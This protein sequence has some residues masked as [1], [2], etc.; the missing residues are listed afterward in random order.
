MRERKGERERERDKQSNGAR[1][2]AKDTA[3]SPCTE[4]ATFTH[5]T[6]RSER[7]SPQSS[8]EKRAVAGGGREGGAGATPPLPPPIPL[9]AFLL[10]LL[11]RLRTCLASCCP[12]RRHP[13]AASA[14]L[15]WL[16]LDHH[17][18]KHATSGQNDAPERRPRL[19]LGVQPLE[20]GRVNQAEAPD[21]RGGD[22]QRH[23]RK[24]LRHRVVPLCHAERNQPRGARRHRRD[25]G[26]AERALK[27]EERRVGGQVRDARRV[28]RRHAVVALQGCAGTRHLQ[29][30]LQHLRAE[31]HAHCAHHAP[32]DL[33]ALHPEQRDADRTGHEVLRVAVQHTRD[34]HGGEREREVEVVEGRRGRGREGEKGGERGCSLTPTLQ[35]R[36][37]PFPPR[38]P[39]RCALRAYI[40]SMKYRYCSF[41]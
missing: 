25:R 19:R 10:S 22:A 37:T 36:N 2:A 6:H 9:P 38:T 18:R 3:P 11:D 8:L 24:H 17:Q 35:R 30:P 4:Q 28:R 7:N 5:K 31:T 41:Y 15:L 1:Q 16:R 23:P 39:H 29:R 13:A 40:I 12:L 34:R 14:A 33:L 32:R 26:G 27:Q 20:E 21:P